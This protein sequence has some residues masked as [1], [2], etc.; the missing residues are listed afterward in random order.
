[1]R[2]YIRAARLV[3]ITAG[4]LLGAGSATALTEVSIGP[5]SAVLPDADAFPDGNSDCYIEVRVDGNLIGI[6]PLVP[7]DN[8]P[9]W[10]A[11]L[12]TFQYVPSSSPFLTV[13]FKAYDHDGLSTEYLGEGLVAYNWVAGTPVT[14]TTSV[15]SPMGPGYT[16]TAGYDAHEVVVPTEAGSWGTVKALFR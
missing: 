1:M 9:S 7:D 4:L 11:A 15:N 12:F 6:T 10:P 14:Y 5:I 13:S 3:I 2:S 16:L 8:S